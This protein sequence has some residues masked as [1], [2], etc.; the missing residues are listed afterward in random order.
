MLA[1]R[2]CE[3]FRVENMFAIGI[4]LQCQHGNK[5]TLL[6]ISETLKN[7]QSQVKQC[8]NAII[9]I[10]NAMFSLMIIFH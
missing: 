9:L 1:L 3:I 10:L 8:L 4:L 6:N 5:I 7:Y 2:I